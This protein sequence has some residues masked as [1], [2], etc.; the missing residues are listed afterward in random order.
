MSVSNEIRD[1]KKSLSAL[2]NLQND[3][4]KLLEEEDAECEDALAYYKQLVDDFKKNVKGESLKYARLLVTNSHFTHALEI[5]NGK[6]ETFIM[7]YF[8]RNI[9]PLNS[10]YDISQSLVIMF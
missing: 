1:L 3:Y 8:A 2:N 7:P 5:E 6:L 4:I 10:K 9:I